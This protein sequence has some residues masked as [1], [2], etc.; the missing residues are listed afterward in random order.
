MGYEKIGKVILGSKIVHEAW[1]ENIQSWITSTECG[2]IHTFLEWEAIY[3]LTIIHH[4]RFI[5]KV[6]VQGQNDMSVL[7]IH[8][9]F[10]NTILKI[11]FY[12]VT[13]VCVRT[14]ATEQMPL[15]GEVGANFCG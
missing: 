12:S 2:S 3:A 5:L 6:A 9:C 13:W 15:V 11:F 10:M 14:I 8:A 7:E 4:H 1:T